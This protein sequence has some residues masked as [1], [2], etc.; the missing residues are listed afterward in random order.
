M[1][2]AMK[3]PLTMSVGVLFATFTSIAG[4]N[5][6]VS[7]EAFLKTAKNGKKIRILCF[8]C[9]FFSRNSWTW[10]GNIPRL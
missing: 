9:S 7:K 6:K 3:C 2:E 4:P 5:G 10:R 1:E 8:F